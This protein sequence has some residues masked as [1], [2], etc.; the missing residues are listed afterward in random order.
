[1]VIRLAWPPAAAVLM[2]RDLQWHPVSIKTAQAV[3]FYRI[4]LQQSNALSCSPILEAD[5]YLQS[6]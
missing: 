2:P 5:A 1:M 6:L 3:M 4:A